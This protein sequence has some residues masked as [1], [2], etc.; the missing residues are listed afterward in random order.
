MLPMGEVWGESLP[1]H[2]IT[3]RTRNDWKFVKGHVDY[4]DLENDWILLRI[5][6]SQDKNLVYD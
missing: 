6:T 4:V 2:A 3:H 5:S 1:L